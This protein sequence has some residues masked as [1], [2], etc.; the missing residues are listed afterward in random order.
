MSDRDDLDPEYRAGST[1]FRAQCSVT[2]YSLE[3]FAEGDGRDRG[4]WLGV[5]DRDPARQ[6]ARLGRLEAVLEGAGLD[7]HS[8]MRVM[9][10]ARDLL[11]RA[12]REQGLLEW[13]Q[14][15]ALRDALSAELARRG[16]Q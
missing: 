15:R 16:E 7:S 2:A 11:P 8:A 3:V 1:A 10:E 9:F 5:E 12:L 14:V 13:D 6:T 4:L